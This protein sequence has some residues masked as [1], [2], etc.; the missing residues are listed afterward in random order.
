MYSAGTKAEAESLAKDVIIILKYL[1]DKLEKTQHSGHSHQVE[2][3]VLEGIYAVLSNLPIRVREHQEFV[4]LIWWANDLTFLICQHQP[5]HFD[6]D[7]LTCFGTTLAEWECL[8]VYAEHQFLSKLICWNVSDCFVLRSYL[9]L[10]GSFSVV[11]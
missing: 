10:D 7:E 1:C 6:D 3:L 4:D 11:H 8:I 5:C 2:P 9:Q